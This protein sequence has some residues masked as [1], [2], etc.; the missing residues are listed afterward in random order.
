MKLMKKKSLG[1]LALTSLMLVGCGEKTSDK[2][3]ED[4]TTIA[5]DKQVEVTWWNNYQTPDASKTEEENRK[6]KNYYEYYYA[7]DLIAEFE[8]A[9]PNIKIDSQYKGNYTKIATSIK[10]GMATGNFP[11][12]ASTYQDNVATY[13][14]NEISYDMTAFAAELEKDTDFNQNYLSIE[15]G[16]FNGKYYSL[17]YSKSGETLAINQSVFDLEGAGKAG[18]DTTKKVTDKE[19]K[20]STV[21]VY[22]A[23]VAKDTKTKYNVPENFYEMI[24]VA[25]KMKADFPDLFKNQRDAKG[26][27]TAVPFCWDSSENMFISLLKNA[28]IAYTNGNGADA[29]AKNTW[30]SDEAKAL[31]MQIKKWNNEGLIAT[32][33]QLPITDEKNQYHE[34]SSNMVTKGTIFMA[35]SSTAGASY[36]ATNGGFKASLNHAMNWKEGTKAKDAKVISQGPSLTFFRNK[37]NDVNKAAFEFY[38][39]LTNT[40]NS[41]KLAVTKAYF[42]LRETS[43]KTETV[44]ALTDAA[45]TTDA[46]AAYKAKYNDYTGQALK[47]NETYTSENAYFMSD[48]FVGSAETR[49][50]VGKLVKDVFDAKLEE[51]DTDVKLKAVVDKAF[52]D[53]KKALLA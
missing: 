51:T 22:T 43:Y 42:P 46:K 29:V 34:Y 4:K 14:D 16:C 13:V 41:A 10:D 17:P 40:E 5:P 30:F 25:R 7:Q 8:A 19:G 28:G 39:F 11:T 47:L 31:M 49:T 27:F 20:E 33:N 24:E 52:D 26:Y 21:A 1:I 48:V 37:D 6:N 3:T 15:K 18:E 12:I 45:G 50:A 36:F 38:K 44:K 9:H 2:V 35:V 32:Q 23:P 53:A